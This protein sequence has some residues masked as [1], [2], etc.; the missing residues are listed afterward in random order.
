MK[1]RSWF[2][3][4]V[5][6]AFVLIT[7][8]AQAQV[9]QL[10]NYQGQLTN[11]SGNPSNGTF[12]M[13]FRIF[14]V[15]TAGT[16][17]Y[18]ETQTVTVS[19]GI[20]NVLI[21][22]V[23]PVPLNLFDSGTERYLEVTVNGT[24]LTP[25]RRFGS[26]P[27]AFSSPS[28][29][30]SGWTDDGTTV[31]LTT[32]TDSVGVGTTRPQANLH[33]S[34]PGDR[35]IDI[36]STDLNGSHTRIRSVAISSSNSGSKSEL[37]FKG[38][39][40]LISPINGNSV[41]EL[42]Q[43]GNVGIGTTNPSEALQVT[44]DQSANNY[45]GIRID[46][47]N[48]T[49]SGERT[50]LLDLVNTDASSGKT[51][52]LQNVGNA[53]NRSGNFEIFDISA[54]SSRLAIS[55]TG[56]VEIGGG[57]GFPHSFGPDPNFVGSPGNYIAFAHQETSEDFIGYK[58]NTFY[59]KDSPGGADI[60]DPTVVVGGKIGI[61]TS[62]PQRKLQIGADAAG[63]GFEGSIASPHAGAIRFGDNS[64]WKFY[65]GRSQEIVNGPLNSGPTGALITIEDKGNVG[66][67]TT[68]PAAKLDV[69]GTFRL[70]TAV[71][72][73]GAPSGNA[74]ISNDGTNTDLIP[75]KDDVGAVRVM[76]GNSPGGLTLV[77]GGYSL[78]NSFSNVGANT[79]SALLLQ[80]N[81]GSVGIGTTNPTQKLYVVGNIYATGT[82]TPGSSRE[83]KENITNLS[84]QEAFATLNGL[85]P[86][87][88]NYK[89]DVEKDL[90]IGFIAEDV[91]ELVAIP[92]RKGVNPMDIVAVLAK[93]VQEQQKAIAA[94]EH[95]VKA[96]E[97]QSR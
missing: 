95:R 90:Q 67:G 45:G 70:G 40:G 53:G 28:S 11:S 35:S 61:G 59:F 27:Y 20:F 82:I 75:A 39:L 51:Y 37:H 66:I 72:G 8:N 32:A 64:G 21:G 96:I 63:I 57:L 33:V 14:D 2:W 24:A 43:N 42:L 55:P 4:I 79:S 23:T 12:T 16:A 44:I 85:N 36:G 58:N 89:A 94:L 60:S 19:G 31:R 26:V 69:S 34:G 10:I 22:S 91:P 17:L 1:A 56:K 6:A 81:G 13:V 86:V 5:V 7:C 71:Y 15:A 97:G 38:R 80:T 49:V 93:V 83:L 62:N 18:T 84:T 88:F 29:G 87:K 3:A 54:G 9:P 78:I 30:A 41:M 47:K 50:V 46:N 73:N 77:N 52:R 92:S 65:I 25:R 76:D 68:S 48:P 74:I